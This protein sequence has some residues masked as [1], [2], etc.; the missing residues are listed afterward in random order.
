MFAVSAKHKD[1]S[2]LLCIVRGCMHISYAHIITNTVVLAHQ[3][4]V[5]TEIVA[6]FTEKCNRILAVMF[7]KGS[8]CITKPN[9]EQTSW[10][11]KHTSD[12]TVH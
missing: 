11:I 4:R 9:F 1:G 12:Y 10:K 2:Y 3:D 8:Y 5:L 6:D 7:E